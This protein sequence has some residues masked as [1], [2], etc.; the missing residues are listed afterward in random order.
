MCIVYLVSL[1]IQY[2]VSLQLYNTNIPIVTWTLCVTVCN[3]IFM[4]INMRWFE[5]ARRGVCPRLFY[6]TT[7][8]GDA[9]IKVFNYF[10]TCM[11]NKNAAFNFVWAGIFGIPDSILQSDS[12][13][14]VSLFEGYSQAKLLLGSAIMSAPA[15]YAVAAVTSCLLFVR[16]TVVPFALGKVC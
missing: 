6:S 11:H 15:H 3:D 1:L 5:R 9:I 10:P 14:E 12:H 2:L 4:H 16:M 8:R 13:S 7:G